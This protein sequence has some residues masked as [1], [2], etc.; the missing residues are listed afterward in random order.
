[1]TEVSCDDRDVMKSKP[2]LLPE[3]TGHSIDRAAYEPAYVQLAMILR[4]QIASGLWQAGE[5]LPTEA[6]LRQRYGVSPATIRR[7][8]NLLS[9]QSLVVTAQG[10]GTFVKPLDLGGAV[11][12]LHELGGDALGR[13]EVQILEASIRPADARV[14]AKLALEPGAQVVYLCRLISDGPS[15]AIVSREYLVY[16]PRRPIVEAELQITSFQGLLQGHRNRGLRHGCA[17]I[18][19]V[20]LSAEE[21]T[22]LRLPPGTAAF[23]VEHSFHDFADKPVSWGWLICRADRV[24]LTAQIG[25]GAQE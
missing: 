9:E 8:I 25:A 18:E 15:P 20:N 13:A 22:W 11:F 10:K 1:M 24:R 23:G 2:I 17:S 4:G 19:A 14:S 7:A 21:A 12:R 3:G 16:D 5:Q 6:Q